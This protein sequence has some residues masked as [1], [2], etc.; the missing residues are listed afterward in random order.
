MHNV[1]GG[2]QWLIGGAQWLISDNLIM[3]HCAPNQVPKF[4]SSEVPKL[5]SSQVPGT[6]SSEIKK[7]KKQSTIIKKKALSTIFFVSLTKAFQILLFAFP[8]KIVYA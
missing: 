6:S 2:A 4:P 1:I 8:P 3:N 5:R 7:F